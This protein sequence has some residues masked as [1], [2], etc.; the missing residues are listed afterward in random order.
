MLVHIHTVIK[1]C[2]VYQG[3]AIDDGPLNQYGTTETDER[4]SSVKKEYS[5][6]FQ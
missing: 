1:K 2:N 3:F 4:K 6:M 5:E